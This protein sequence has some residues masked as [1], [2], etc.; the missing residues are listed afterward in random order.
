MLSRTCDVVA[1]AIPN[2]CEPLPQ[3]RVSQALPTP[4]EK[5]EL[6]KFHEV[7]AYRDKVWGPALWTA[8]EAMILSMPNSL[9]EQEF[10]SFKL[11]LALS[12]RYM[13]CENCGRHF[14]QHLVDMPNTIAMRTRAGLIKW[15]T[16]VKNDVNRRN[17]KPILSVDE[18]VNLLSE[19]GKG[20]EHD[21]QKKT[22]TKT[23]TTTTT[24]PTTRSSTRSS[25]APSPLSIAL[26]AAAVVVLFIVMWKWVP[27]KSKK[28]SRK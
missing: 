11:Y 1:K 6:A 21:G 25:D 12:A 2:L 8:L 16:D 4:Q 24:N 26:L 23:K 28:S 15:L 7:K 13:P 3:A 9:D 22:T 5:A 27:R 14:T 18:I 20:G 10:C 19:K 17:G